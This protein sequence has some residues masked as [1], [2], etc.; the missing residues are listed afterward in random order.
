[1]KDPF[2]MFSRKKC[3]NWLQIVMQVSMSWF[4]Q[5]AIVFSKIL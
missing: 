3:N 4:A 2:Q 1:M 5:T